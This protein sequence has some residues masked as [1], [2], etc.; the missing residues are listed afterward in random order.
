MGLFC[1]GGFKLPTPMDTSLERASYGAYQPFKNNIEGTTGFFRAP[2]SQEAVMSAA[3]TRINS[4][5]LRVLVAP[6]SWGC[7]ALTLSMIV[8]KLQ[9]Q[10]QVQIDT[11]DI[12]GLFTAVA[13]QKKYPRK[14]LAG[15][16]ADYS[17][18][19]NAASVEQFITP[20]ETVSQ[21]V[22]VLPAG[23]ISDFTPDAPYDVVFCMNM[24]RHI[25][26]G[27]IPEVIEKLATLAKHILCF[28]GLENMSNSVASAS[29]VSYEKLQVEL[30]ETFGFL[31]ASSSFK[32][33]PINR[34]LPVLSEEGLREACFNVDRKQDGNNFVLLRE[35]G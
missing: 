5:P 7:E 34:S 8:E 9:P 13:M 15:I 23:N 10:A 4:K 1:Y 28:N 26:Y 29:R 31:I 30:R 32:A 20:V 27:K 17:H 19:F 35:L 3:M 11:L 25:E 2:V 12:S 14:M 21:R 16:P 6:G 24:L 22:N 33:H 18:M